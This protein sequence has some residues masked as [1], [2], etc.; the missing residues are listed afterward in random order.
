MLDAAMAWNLLEG[1]SGYPHFSW[2]FCKPTKEAQEEGIVEELSGGLGVPFLMMS[3]TV[4]S[5][6]FK[7]RPKVKQLNFLNSLLGELRWLESRDVKEEFSLDYV[8]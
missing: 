5:R 6:F 4:R 2:Y 3:S 7:Q 8:R 1:L